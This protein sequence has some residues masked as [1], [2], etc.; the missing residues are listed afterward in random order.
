MNMLAGERR[1]VQIVGAGCPACRQL[2][3]DVRA[4]ITRHRIEAQVE[5]VDDLV[6]ILNYRLLA[7]P[8]LVIDGRVILAGYPPRDRLDRVLLDTLAAIR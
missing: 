2:E 4:W 8:G 5:R 3:A 1:L 6:E 7:L